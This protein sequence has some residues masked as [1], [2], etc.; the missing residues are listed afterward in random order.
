[1]QKAQ[2][3]HFSF[4][5][6]RTITVEC[7]C[8]RVSRRAYSQCSYKQVIQVNEHL[9][10]S[11][12]FVSLCYFMLRST[13]FFLMFIYIYMYQNRSSR[14]LL[15]LEPLGV[16]QEKKQHKKNVIDYNQA[17]HSV[18]Y[19]VWAEGVINNFYN[20]PVT[21]PVDQDVSKICS[22][23]FPTTVNKSLFMLHL[24]LLVS[25]TGKRHF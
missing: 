25:F 8:W 9:Q 16:D 3:G 5:S 20:S 19:M 22:K 12:G 4:G 15:N 2:S 24:H 10:R 18:W 17:F 11:K 23:C 6:G 21:A 14:N 7:M 1:M 13:F